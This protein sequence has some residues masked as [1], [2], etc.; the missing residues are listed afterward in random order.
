MV[1]VQGRKRWE[2]WDLWADCRS[3]NSEAVRGC[4]CLSSLLYNL[5]WNSDQCGNNLENKMEQFELL[6]PL[7][8]WQQTYEVQQSQQHH[9]WCK[10]LK[11]KDILNWQHSLTLQPPVSWLCHMC[12]RKE[13]HW[14]QNQ[15]RQDQDNSYWMFGRTTSHHICERISCCIGCYPSQHIFYWTL[16]Q[17]W[18][19]V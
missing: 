11:L 14:G 18:N 16:Q 12:R 5:G 15:Q 4:S 13:P 7:L 10:W 9:T 19:P 8:H 1:K 3:D 2:R 6:R 17:P